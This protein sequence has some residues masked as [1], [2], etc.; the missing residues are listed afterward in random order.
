M[1]ASHDAKTRGVLAEI[2]LPRAAAVA[3]TVILAVAIQSTVLVQATIL[4]VVP[5][6][7]L[8][9][10]VAFAYL[11]GERVGVVT[12]FFGGLF[13]DLLPP[14]SILGLTAL[15][16][17]L[18][19]YTVGSARYFTPSESV[20]SPVLLVAG[21]SIASEVGYAGLSIILGEEWVSLVFTA[22]VAG[23]VILYN[24]LLTPFVFP[25]VKRIANKVRPER[26]G[27][28]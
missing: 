9:V 27:R 23:L 6:L 17:T 5:Q 26:V 3:A 15:V 7:V 11:D 28:W 21:A 18:I 4:R 22:K 13:L 10:V 1:V 25:L 16:Y 12:G 14:D 8:V 2:G 19:G 24:T 20:W